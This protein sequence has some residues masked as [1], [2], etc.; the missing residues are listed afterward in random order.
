MRVPPHASVTAAKYGSSLAG[1]LSPQTGTVNLVR[2]AARRRLGDGLDR[3]RIGDEAGRVVRRLADQVGLERQRPLLVGG[4]EVEALGDLCR[5]PA[6]LDVGAGGGEREA[7][8]PGGAE[9][10]GLEQ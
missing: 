5:A 10:S 3:L 9:P 2:A 1:T 6:R 4:K 7:R 8:G